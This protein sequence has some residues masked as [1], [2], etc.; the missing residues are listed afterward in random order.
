MRLR[1]ARAEGVPAYV[2]FHDKTLVA[3]AA[4]R[5]QTLNDLAAIPGVGPAKLARYGDEILDVLR[6]ARR[7]S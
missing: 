7:E 3:I 1:R 2:V 6:R 5:P 4:A